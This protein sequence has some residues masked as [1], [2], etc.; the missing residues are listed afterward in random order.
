MQFG[1]ENVHGIGMGWDEMRWGEM[2]W[3]E[4]SVEEEN[5]KKNK[6]AKKKVCEEE[7]TGIGSIRN[8]FS[9]LFFPALG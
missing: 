9:H 6:K 2:R 1:R 7:A 5:K 8:T 4:L 3:G